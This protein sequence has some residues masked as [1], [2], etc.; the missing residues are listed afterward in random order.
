MY[1]Y[2]K[3]TNLNSVVIARAYETAL[4]DNS[5]TYVG[6]GV[7]ASEAQ[8]QY[9]DGIE[10]NNIVFRNM[11]GMKKIYSSD[12]NLVVPDVAWANSTI[13]NQFNS[14]EEMYLHDNIVELTGNVSYA[15]GYRITGENSTTLFQNELSI[16]DIIEFNIP[17]FLDST[18]RRQVIAVSNN[19]SIN[20][21]STITNGVSSSFGLEGGVPMY[22]VTANYPRYAKSFYVRNTF[23]QVF[24]CIFNNGDTKSTVEPILRPENFSMGKLIQDL[25]DGYVWRYLYTIPSGLKEKFFFTDKDSVRWMPVTTDTIVASTAVDGAI[26]SLRIANGGTGYNSNTACSNVDM[27]T[28]TGDGSSALF[29]GNVVQS[30]SINSTTIASILSATGGSGYSYANVVITDAT[31]TGANFSALIGPPRGFGYDPSKDLG[32]KFLAL[33]VEFSDTVGGAVPIDTDAG[34]VSFRQIS[35]V[36]DPLYSNGAIIST[37]YVP[38]TSNVRIN[39]TVSVAVGDIANQTSGFSGTVVAFNNPYLLLNNVTGTFSENSGIA[40]GTGTAIATPSVKRSGDI[41]YVDNI[42]SVSRDAQQAEQIKIVFKF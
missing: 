13:Y 11:I 41:L 2:S 27:I 16:G 42:Q 26:E 29:F 32:A 38:M 19:Y 40:G 1:L 8:H 36:R 22:K 21:N 24:I 18:I 28:V 10:N 15:G 14:N 35:I 39:G 31:G 33:S 20:I 37:A 30:S 9:L 25:G 7:A 23:D 3:P 4:T 5:N 6:L 34:I 17:D 12:V